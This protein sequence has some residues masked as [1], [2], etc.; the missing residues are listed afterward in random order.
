MSDESGIIIRAMHE[1]NGL[2]VTNYSVT[3]LCNG[4]L[5]F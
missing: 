2:G 1:S 4:W 3:T 5:Y